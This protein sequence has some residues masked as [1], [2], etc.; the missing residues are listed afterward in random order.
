MD[1]WLR[2][3]RKMDQKLRDAPIG[4]KAPAIMGGH[5]YRTARGWKWNGP[6]GSGGTFPRPGGDWD[7]E[8]IYPEESTRHD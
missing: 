3:A 7:G 2:K 1:G 8:L 4:T 6:D 5:W